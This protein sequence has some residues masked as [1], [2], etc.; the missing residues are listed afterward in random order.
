MR[1]NVAFATKVLIKRELSRLTIRLSANTYVLI[2]TEYEV[3]DGTVIGG[4]HPPM[5]GERMSSG[6]ADGGQMGGVA[7]RSATAGE[8]E[9]MRATNAE[10][11]EMDDPP[12][13]S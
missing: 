2:W 11:D 8:E 10:L 5:G 7:V 6:A 13:Q 9:R 3:N 12:A 1:R 4:R